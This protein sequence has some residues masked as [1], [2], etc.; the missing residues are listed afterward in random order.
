[1]HR[2]AMT[3][4]I[5]GAA[6]AVAVLEAGCGDDGEDQAAVSY[7]RTGTTGRVADPGDEA[8]EMLREADRL[9]ASEPTEA[10][11]MMYEAAELGARSEDE[12]IR[13]AA[14]AFLATSSGTDVEWTLA[15]MDFG[16][17]CGL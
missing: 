13:T 8:C 11:I 5:V 4:T 9:I 1:M 16:G 10:G 15:Y 3:R 12:A 6:L 17:A 7:G 2:S 14:S